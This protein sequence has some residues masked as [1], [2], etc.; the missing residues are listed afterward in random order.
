MRI[1]VAHSRYASGNV[2]GENRVVE[3][4]VRLLS[5]AG[6]DVVSWT[7]SGADVHPVR[8][9]ARATWAR[10]ASRRLRQLTRAHRAD[11]V[12]IHN[13]FPMISPASIRAVSTEAPVVLTLHNY[14]LLCLPATLFRDGRICEDCVGRSL[15]RGVIHG[16]Y[17]K[18]RL[19]SG[20]LAASL[21]L[22]RRID[23]FKGVRRFL[24]VSEFVRAKHRAAGLAADI[25]V[26]PNFAWARDRRRG[27][28]SH[29]VFAGRL[30]PEKG[31]D[32]IVDAWKN[33]RETLIVAGDG[34]QADALRRL[35]P[36]NVRFVGPCTS[37]EV[38]A[39]L[40]DAR[41]LLVPS[42]CY[43]GAPRSIIEAFATG[44]PVVAPS[45]GSLAEI[46]DDG[47]NGVSIARSS[48]AT[49][50]GAIDQLRDDHVVARLGAG[51]WETWS[52]RYSPAANLAALE[53]TYRDI[54]A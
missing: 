11:V 10:D 37:A 50:M 36:P 7:P 4:E 32:V 2:S 9:A 30:T 21:E 34:E 51:A 6:H 53:A 38:D 8:A 12:H 40:R 35:A 22:H 48:A 13:L 49:W 15:A 1:L 41:A 42:R 54:A 20:A 17:R 27:A 16:C 29:Y 44:V 19:A 5:E 26:K 28:G 3:D 18:S 52:S 43:E 25:R 14:R 23:S 47:I 24:A 31:L 46:V 45:L 33:V 39:L